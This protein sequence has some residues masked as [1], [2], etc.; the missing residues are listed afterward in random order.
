MAFLNF[1]IILIVLVQMTSGA[2]TETTCALFEP[3]NPLQLSISEVHFS[4]RAGETNDEFIELSGPS[5]GANITLE[6]YYFMSVV[7]Q[8]KGLLCNNRRDITTYVSEAKIIFHLKDFKL[9]DKG[10]VYFWTLYWWF[11]GYYFTPRQCHRQ[12]QIFTAPPRFSE[13]WSCFIL[14]DCFLEKR[15]FC[16]D[17]FDFL[18]RALFSQK[19]TYKNDATSLLLVKSPCSP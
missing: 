9:S 6:G 19:Q 18:E 16:F 10:R 2:V 13:C 17:A 12:S 1:L 14:T 5:S 4:K 8:K 11:F 15:S 7:L 3:R